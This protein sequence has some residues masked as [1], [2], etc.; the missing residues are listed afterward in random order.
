MIARMKA[1]PARL[2]TTLP[3]TCGVSRGAEA[4]S[5]SVEAVVVAVVEGAVGPAGV[6]KPP[7]PTPT[8]DVDVAV[9]DT[10]SELSKGALLDDLDA[11]GLLDESGI[12]VLDGRDAAD[13]LSK[14]RYGE[15]EKAED[16][17]DKDDVEL[18]DRL[19]MAGIGVEDPPLLCGA[20]FGD[21]TTAAELE[22]PTDCATGIPEGHG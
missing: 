13:G 1:A 10:V 16:G 4:D 20:L 7:T 8:A 21:D 15:M 12:R 18:E 9:S 22:L 17:I 11:D 2:P 3:T 6:S 5:V 14:E 19:L